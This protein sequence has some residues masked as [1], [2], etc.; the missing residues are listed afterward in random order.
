MAYATSGGQLR[1]A[2]L[3]GRQTTIV[4]ASS[5]GC[6][7]VG[8]TV[9]GFEWS[10]DGRVIAVIASPGRI[11]ELWLAPVDGGR[12]RLL[13]PGTAD[14]RPGD[15]PG[16]HGDDLHTLTWS[17]DGSSIAVTGTT[18]RDGSGVG[19]F[20]RV[21][22][23]EGGSLQTL[24][25]DVLVA[26]NAS[27]IAPVWSSDGKRIAYQRDDG[28][29]VLAAPDASDMVVLPLVE[30][31]TIA[32]RPIVPDHGLVW[33]PDGQRLLYTGAP[34]GTGFTSFVLMSVPIEPGSAAIAL[35]PLTPGLDVPTSVD[36]TWQPVLP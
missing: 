3:D 6:C 9:G 36:L 12:I 27:G 35:T 8:D 1:V 5:D 16:T 22:D 15:R 29:I 7:V 23:V 21:L 20:I 24:T 10:P 26:A 19:T 18:V 13:E 33:S 31:P 14:D 34:E 28:R 30:L 32:D 25:T 4:A 17:P 11:D 2:T